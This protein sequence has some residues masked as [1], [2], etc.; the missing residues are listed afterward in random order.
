[1]TSKSILSQ[2]RGFTLIEISIV[3]VVIGLLLSGGLVALAPVI[4]N[5][6]RTESKNQL[7]K[8]EDALLLWVIQSN[9]CL[10]CPADGTLTG[11]SANNGLG[12][13]NAGT[14]QTGPTCPADGSACDIQPIAINHAGAV[15]TNYAG[16]TPWR[17]LGLSEA[18]TI[19]GW[20][21]R[22]AYAV[23]DTLLIDLTGGGEEPLERQAG[24]PPT[25]GVGALTVTDTAA[26]NITTTAAYVLVSRGSDGAFGFKI[27][28]PGTGGAKEDGLGTAGGIQGDNADADDIYVQGDPID[29]NGA[30]YFDDIVQWKTGP[31]ITFQCGSGACGNP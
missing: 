24:T 1:M 10:P 8:I 12:L 14:Q 23:S 30:G 31:V 6:K 29:I 13:V 27:S 9:G 26:A 25:F 28:G 20:G 11:A 19:D 18:D 16:V 3:L 7:T 5:A 2:M 15:N 21:N 4:E 22:I 17:T